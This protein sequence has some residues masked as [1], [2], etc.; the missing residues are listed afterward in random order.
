MRE[1]ATTGVHVSTARESEMCYWLG[2]SVCDITRLNVVNLV[3]FSHIF[4][5][6]SYYGSLVKFEYITFYFI[7]R[8]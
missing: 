5:L 2:T 1:I 3:R 7:F 6:L 4:F 8:K